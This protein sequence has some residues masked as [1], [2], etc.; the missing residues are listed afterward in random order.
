MERERGKGTWKG[1]VE[2][3]AEQEREWKRGT[4]NGNVKSERGTWNEGW[5]WDW[6]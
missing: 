3:N 5:D 1:N 2:R 6:D 4:W